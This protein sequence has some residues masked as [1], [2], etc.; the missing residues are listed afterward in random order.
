M[1]AAVRRVAATP[2][3]RRC[4]SISRV[5]RDHGSKPAA[6]AYTLDRRDRRT[7]GRTVYRYIDPAAYYAG[8]FNK[9]RLTQMNLRDELPHT[10]VNAQCDRLTTDVGVLSKR[11][12]ESSCLWHGSYLPSILHCV[13]RKFRYLQNNGYFK[14]L[15][16]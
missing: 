8:S 7:D 13:K 10:E 15:Q 1:S 14:Y 11:L 6:A 4:R 9:Y 12:N 3:G 16:K 5:V 2:G